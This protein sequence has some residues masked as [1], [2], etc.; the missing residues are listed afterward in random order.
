MFMQKKLFF[1]DVDGT[2]IDEGTKIFPQ[3]AVNAIRALRAAG[4]LVFINS[5]RTLCLLEYEMETF[6]I[7]CAACGCGTQIIVNGN[8]LMEQRIAHR[9]GLEIRQLIRQLQLDA[10]LEAQEA[11]YF[12]DR[13]FKNPE[14]MEG[15]LDYISCYAETEVNALE[16]NSYD[17]DKFCIQTSPLFPER[18]LVAKLIAEASDFECIDRGRG[19][20]EFV[21]VGCSKGSAVNFVRNHYG[22]APEDCYVFG[23]SANDLTMFT[24][25]AGNRIAM[26]VHDTVLEPYA[27]MITD[28]VLDDGIAKALHA[29]RVL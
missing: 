19:F 3:S 10:V 20:Y 22:I 14:L 21:P 8:T 18:K 17:F 28:K 2:L 11:I 16:D 4:H 27:T 29:L 1:F 24:S 7:S 15:L 26:A 6:G 13:P 5:G 23:D 9:R 25:E 12:S